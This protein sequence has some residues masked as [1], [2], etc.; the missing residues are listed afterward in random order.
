MNSAS[1]RKREEQIRG[2]ETCSPS[3]AGI[4]APA[5]GVSRRDA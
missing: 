2:V 4:A 1:S 5:G 3:G